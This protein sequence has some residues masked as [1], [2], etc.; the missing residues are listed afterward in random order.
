MQDLVFDADLLYIAEE[1]L[2]SPLPPGWEEFHDA[3]G[4]AYYYNK[5][6][7]KTQ[8]CSP[9]PNTLQLNLTAGE[10]D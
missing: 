3:N 7:D 1:L 4:R 8:V 9:D 10:K 6:E 5:E 2:M